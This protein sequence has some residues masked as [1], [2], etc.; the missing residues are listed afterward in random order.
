MSFLTDHNLPADWAQ[1]NSE[2]KARTL[3]SK[4]KNFFENNVA[5]L[6]RVVDEGERIFYFRPTNPIESIGSKPIV[7]G[8]YPEDFERRS[9]VARVGIYHPRL[10]AVDA[11]CGC[12]DEV[13]DFIRENYIQE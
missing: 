2:D 10:P 1:I 11:Y 13:V 5:H 7:I 9:F 6:G 3:G 4:L 8:F 12:A